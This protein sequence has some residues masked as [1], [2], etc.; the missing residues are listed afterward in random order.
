MAVRNI[1]Y[2]DNKFL[3]K[4]CKEVTCV[5]DKIRQNLDDMMDTLHNTEHG[6]ALAAKGYC[7]SFE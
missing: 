1:R 7:S 5:D 3:R 6:A 4:K 2:S